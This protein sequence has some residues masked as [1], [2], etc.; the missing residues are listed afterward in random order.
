MAISFI[1]Q[2]GAAAT[3]VTVPAHAI[4]DYIVIAAYRT[5]IT[6]PTLPAG[7]KTIVTATGNANS[8]RIG[9]KV[10][11]S[12]SDTSGTWTNATVLNCAVYRG[13]TGVGRTGVA[14]TGAAGTTTAIPTFTLDNKNGKS[15]VVAFA[16]SKQAT[17]QGTPLAGA[18]TLRGTQI[19]TTSDTMLAD[20]NAGVSTFSATTSA[21]GSSVVSAGASF[22][23]LSSDNMST[24]AD[25]FNALTLNSTFWTQF[26]AG[27][28]TLT[29]DATGAKATFPAT[30]SSATDGDINS[31]VGYDLTGS[32]AYIHIL[33]NT[34]G[35]NNDNNFSLWDSNDNTNVLQWQIEAGSIFAQHQINGIQTNDFS[36]T[37][38]LTTHAWLR[39]RESG[40]T[41]FWDTAPDASGLPGTWVNRF[42][43]ASPIR[44]TNL[45][46]DIGAISFGVDTSAGNF[47]WINLNPSTAP[48]AAITQ[49]AAT[50]TATGGTQAIATVNNVAISQLAATV[51]ATGG[52][53]TLLAKQFVTLAQIAGNI[54]ATG[55]TQS[56]ATVNNVA[57][58]QA[59]A[60][61]TA[62][63]GT[64]AI[65]T[66]NFVAISQ[67][68]ATLTAT[69]GTQ[70]AQTRVTIAQVAGT[71]TATGGTQ[72]VATSNFVA[73]TQ[74]AA[75]LTATGGTQAA[76]AAFQAN[77]SQV[78]ATIT[79]TGGTQAVATVNK[80]A[81][82][83]A[84]A[85]L[86]ATGGTQVVA[87]QRLVNIVQVKAAITATGGTQAVA[88]KTSIA[89]GQLAATLTVR[90]GT[91][92]MLIPPIF[93]PLTATL[94]SFTND[95]ESTSST[96]I[97]DVP[98]S[99]TISN[100]DSPT[101]QEALD[102]L[103]SDAILQSETNEG[104]LG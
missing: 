85:T 81:I 48:S 13:V 63:G 26:T 32:A 103:G 74:V 1:G 45:Y 16:G 43:I 47:K 33:Q 12:T 72:S 80:V 96:N 89:L 41:I 60:T 11:T 70:T 30:S 21:N 5:A 56:I 42:S 54:T 104:I 3:T 84:H 29:F 35:T 31:V 82:T 93:V 14:G 91:Q 65:A 10:A 34:S 78:A 67:V 22:E 94:S 38:S 8:V 39:I 23:L 88:S 92:V 28:A 69:G 59:H 50:V 49:V 9:Y 52:T 66:T 20:T 100:V 87:S 2:A 98:S 62:T 40:G 4:G 61:L 24:F 18:T 75:T 86:T 99:D 83:Q 53:Q 90:G 19:G 76:I 73:I 46:F 25:P 68:G 37:Y 7:F 15:W 102:N 17:S 57:I 95:A 71:L 27:S 101:N 6:A 64:Q 44:I 58:T 55:G 77:I 97:A 51:T 36:T 79:A